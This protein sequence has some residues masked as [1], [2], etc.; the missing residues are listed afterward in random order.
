MRVPS[1]NLGRLSITENDDNGIKSIVYEHNPVVATLDPFCD[2]DHNHL[3]L[4]G[5]LKRK[6]VSQVR[7]FT[8]VMRLWQ[9]FICCVARWGCYISKRPLG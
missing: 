7:N 2:C 4:I 6:L 5:L 3:T 9:N 8:L 1:N